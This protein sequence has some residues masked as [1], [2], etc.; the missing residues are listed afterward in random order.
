MYTIRLGIPEV[1]ALWSDL[2]TKADSGFLSKD[3]EKA[4]KKWG[5]AMLHLAMDP[6]HTGLHSHEIESLSRRYGIR[7]W[8]S[9]LENNTPA[10]GRLFWV[11]GPGRQEITVIGI[12]PHPEDQK[13]D[14]YAKVR[15]SSLGKEVE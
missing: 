10:A 13:K 15:L 14:G 1:E 3:E 2:K 5:K 11:Y 7:V 8:Q 9:Y 4:Y 6:R 12:E